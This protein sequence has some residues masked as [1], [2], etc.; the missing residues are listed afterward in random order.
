MQ[1]YIVKLIVVVGLVGFVRPSEAYPVFGETEICT[2]NH[3][4][5]AVYLMSMQHSKLE[6]LP[7]YRVLKNIW[8]GTCDRQL[9]RRMRDILSKEIDPSYWFNFS[10]HL[11]KVNGEFFKTFF[12]TTCTIEDRKATLP[13]EIKQ[14]FTLSNVSEI[15]N[16]LVLTLYIISYLT[17]EDLSEIEEEKI[18]LREVIGSILGTSYDQTL[19]SFFE[20]AWS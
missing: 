13:N 12:P 10:C 5:N 1:R 18:P 16:S 3:Y 9:L 4:K 8:N 7:Y 2:D 17:D 15:P 11:G 14:I 19:D 20:P 6:D